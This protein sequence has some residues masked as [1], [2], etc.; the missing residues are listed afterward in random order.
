M[1]MVG[2]QLSQT[3]LLAIDRAEWGEKAG[4]DKKYETHQAI[5]FWLNFNVL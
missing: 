1:R 2:G 4:S 3:G 5:R